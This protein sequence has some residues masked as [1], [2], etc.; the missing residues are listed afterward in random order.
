[1]RY[2][3]NCHLEYPDTEKYCSKCGAEL[4]FR[5]TLVDRQRV[6][7]VLK[8]LPGY[9]KIL[10]NCTL[11]CD[12]DLVHF[13]YLMIHEA[14]VFAFQISE[15]YRFIEGNDRRRYW[16]VADLTGKGGTYALERPVTQ[17]EKDHHILDR[18]LRRYTFAKSF[19]YLL[20]PDDSGLEHIVSQHL[21][22][23]LTVPRMTAILLK[24]IDRYGH[25]YDKT[26][27]DKLG[28]LFKNTVNADA[29]PRQ[30]EPA[31]DSTRAEQRRRHRIFAVFSLLCA[32]ALALLFTV[33]HGELSLPPLPSV[34]ARPALSQ[35][36]PGVEYSLSPACSAV[37]SSV[38]QASL[39]KA[40]PRFGFQSIKWQS[41]ASLHFSIDDHRQSAALSAMSRDISDTFNS[42]LAQKAL[43]HITSVRTDDSTQLKLF[44]TSA[45]LTETE[46]AAVTEVLRYGLVCALLENRSPDDV[47]V[48][49]LG[50]SGETV[51]KISA[52][53]FIESQK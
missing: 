28:A 36:I 38:D 4:S 21:N 31:F 47:I 17:L 41:D 15:S 20:Y 43:P 24:D 7:T 26:Q 9:K 42:L 45:S 51:R 14:G 25:A 1:M 53:D 18:L 39:D 32:V 30:V 10:Q 19:A 16:T 6:M 12:D 37:F 5:P 48:S 33:Y 22:Q 50:Q 49:V 3:D 44:V 11:R 40:A 35:A 34:S 8:S 2:C 46:S 13:D 23:M 29:A 52:A 27:I